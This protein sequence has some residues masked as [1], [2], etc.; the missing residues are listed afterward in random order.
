[1][2]PINEKYE[3]SFIQGFLFQNAGEFANTIIFCVAMDI[4]IDN[5]PN[6]YMVLLE[7]KGVFYNAT[8][9]MSRK[10]VT[11]GM[12]GLQFQCSSSKFS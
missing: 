10:I 6:L 5:A 1:M 11:S 9:S 7:T 12:S 2:F 4:P 8:H 3:T